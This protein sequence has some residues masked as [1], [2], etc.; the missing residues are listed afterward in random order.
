MGQCDQKK[1]A[2][3]LQ[4]LTKND[5]TRKMKD[6]QKLPMNVGDLGKLIIA[7]GFKNYPKSNKSPDLVT[8]L[9]AQNLFYLIKV[10]AFNYAVKDNK[11]EF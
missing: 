2:K 9:W 5:F 3:C 7:K 10:A 1:I 8:L 4:K 11:R 6:L